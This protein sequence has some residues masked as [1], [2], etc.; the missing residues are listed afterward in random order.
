MPDLAIEVIQ[1]THRTMREHKLAS[2]L[3]HEDLGFFLTTC[4]YGILSADVGDDVMKQKVMHALTAVEHHDIWKTSPASSN[5]TPQDCRLLCSSI[6]EAID[7]I[8]AKQVADM[9]AIDLAYTACN[10]TTRK[11]FHEQKAGMQSTSGEL[12]KEMLVASEAV[13]KMFKQYK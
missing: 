5:V 8:I 3:P 6:K 2:R 9:H 4:N 11:R 13:G 10:K 1:A 7:A 12:M